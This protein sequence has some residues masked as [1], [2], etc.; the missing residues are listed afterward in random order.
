MVRY[1]GTREHLY[2]VVIPE[3]YHRMDKFGAADVIGYWMYDN[4]NEDKVVHM[5]CDILIK[6]YSIFDKIEDGLNRAGVV[7]TVKSKKIV[8][9]C[10][11][12]MNSNLWAKETL[13]Q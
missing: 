10:M 4:R 3:K 9:N 11:F 13:A 5:D 12:G 7:T 2:R 1:D 8:A 6:D